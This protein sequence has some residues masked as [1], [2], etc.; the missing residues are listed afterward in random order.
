MALT[1]QVTEQG[2]MFRARW[3]GDANCTFGASP[4]EARERLTR[5]YKAYG[6]MPR[7]HSQFMREKEAPY[8]QVAK[9]VAR[10]KHK[11]TRD[12]YK[13]AHES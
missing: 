1:I 12:V 9:R 2:G 7:E 13:P 6:P 4:Q 8:A 5:E 10:N 3:A 11:R